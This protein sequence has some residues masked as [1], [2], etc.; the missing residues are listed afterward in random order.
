MQLTHTLT[1]KDKRAEFG[2]DFPDKMVM[3][4]SA[5]YDTGD[6]NG[7]CGFGSIRN[8]S[9][10]ILP[11]TIPDAVL[12]ILPEKF[13]K[14]VYA[15]W[16]L[17]GK[18]YNPKGGGYLYRL[19]EHLAYKKIVSEI[20]IDDDQWGR[21]KAG[22]MLSDNVIRDSIDQNGIKTSNFMKWCVKN[23]VGVVY[24][25]PMAVNPVHKIR[26]DF[27]IVQAFYWI[28]PKSIRYNTPDRPI[29]TSG[30]R[31]LPKLAQ[32]NDEWKAHMPRVVKQELGVPSDGQEEA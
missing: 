23:R 25:M 12:K 9:G 31:K 14:L 32:F 2:V 20:D 6:F 15:D 7:N 27:S 18:S 8:V 1:S 21:R 11:F 30:H 26:T 17:P 19:A 22:Y 3:Q 28:P 5:S 13:D 4:V 29:K 24:A 10:N 16:G